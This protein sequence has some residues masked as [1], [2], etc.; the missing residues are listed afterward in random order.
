MTVRE[1]LVMLRAR[2]VFFEVLKYIYF[3]PRFSCNTNT[4]FSV[5][6]LLLLFF[7][8]SR[9]LHF[10]NRFDNMYNFTI[11]T[12]DCTPRR[13]CTWTITCNPAI[14]CNPE[15]PA[16]EWAE[17]APVCPGLP[18]QAGSV[19]GSCHPQV[20]QGSCHPQVLQGRCRCR[21]RCPKASP[22]SSSCLLYTTLQ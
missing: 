12:P 21:C 4:K 2:K 6:K 15:A 14:T 18:H 19:E 22:P 3:L 9:S 7:I 17:L 10:Y 1:D 16:L 20:L 11:K 13:V 5:K 8:Y